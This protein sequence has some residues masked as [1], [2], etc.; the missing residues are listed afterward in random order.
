MDDGA[1]GI[2]GGG[3]GREALGLGQAVPEGQARAEGDG[4]DRQPPAG[5]PQCTNAAEL[6]TLQGLEDVEGTGAGDNLVGDSGPNQLLGRGGPDD[7]LSGVGDDLIL[8][9]SGDSDPVVDCGEGFDTA[10]ID[11]SPAFTDGPPVACESIE[12]R[13]P[14]SFRP[15]DTPPN[16]EP[17]PE[18]QTPPPPPLPPEPKKPKPP[19]P[20]RTP[21]ATRLGRH[22][23]PQLFT[24]NARRRVIFA[25]SASEPGSSFRCRIDRKPYRSC[26]SPRAYLVGPGTHAFRVFAID[27]AGN[28][29]RTPAAFRFRLSR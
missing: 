6:T 17:E 15:P 5:Q 10:L 20:D 12:E 28:R 13:A 29:D 25:F 14:N 9:N 27:A 11:F 19:K 18:T 1:V 2:G 21:P 8:A 3:D 22:P 7:M 26:R 4:V 23:P 24:A 16:P